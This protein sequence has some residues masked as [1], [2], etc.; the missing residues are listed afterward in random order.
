MTK[1][2]KDHETPI[3]TRKDKP[4]LWATCYH[5]LH[6]LLL[7]KRF[8]LGLLLPNAIIVEIHVQTH[9]SVKAM[10]TFVVK[11]AKWSMR[12]FQS[13]TCANTMI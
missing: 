6:H 1:I 8:N 11:A 4:I 12:S 5:P 7:P 3:L 2:I 9:I 10:P 13:T